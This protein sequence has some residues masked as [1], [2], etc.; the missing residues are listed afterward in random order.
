ML[1]AFRSW[2]NCHVSVKR[3]D[4]GKRN[5]PMNYSLGMK[6]VQTVKDLRSER[7]RHV[8]TKPTVLSQNT[9]NRTTRNIFEE[10]GRRLSVELW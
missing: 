10:T 9:S 8:L 7:L 5:Y 2:N 6:V 3:E 1:S 4:T